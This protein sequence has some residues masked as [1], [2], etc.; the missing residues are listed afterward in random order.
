[1]HDARAIANF[2]IDRAETQRRQLTIMTLLKVMYFSHAWYLV[3]YNKP[4]IGQPFEA[5]KYG[6][7]NRVVYDQCKSLPGGVIKNK[8]ISF[9]VE[10]ACFSETNYNFESE[11]KKF[12]QEMFDYYSSFHAFKLSDLTHEKG[13]PWDLVWSEAGERAIPGM[14]IPNESIRGWFSERGALYWTNRAKEP[15]S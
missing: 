14:V 12:L 10:Q 3:K 7:V 5:W 1:M 4:L 9:N 11:T 13:S 8:L 6:P 2:F 15:L